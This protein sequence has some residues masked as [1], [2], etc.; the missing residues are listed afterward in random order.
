MKRTSSFFLLAQALVVALLSAAC[1]HTTPAFRDSNG[2]VHANSIAEETYLDTRASRQ[3]L[4]VRGRDRANPAVIFVHGGPGG[5]E[6]ALMRAFNPELEDDLVM[7]YWD[8]RGAGKSY[9]ADTHLNTMTVAQFLQDMDQ[10]VD[11]LRE[12]LGKA[13]IVVMGHFWGSVLGMLYTQRFPDKVA[14]YIGVGQIASYRQ[15]ELHA[16]E[17]V[18]REAR[19]RRDER[20]L[21]QLRKIGPP[22]YTH[23]QVHVRD[24]WLHRYGGYTHAS[25]SLPNVVWKALWTPEA[26]LA[27]LW[28]VW[29]GL[30]RSQ[31]AMQFEFARLDLTNAVLTVE[32]P[33]TFILG[34]YDERT[35]APLAEAYLASLQ[36]PAKRLVW[37]ENSAHNGPFEEPAAFR[38]HVIEAVRAYQA[39]TG[40]LHSLQTNHLPRHPGR[41]STV[42]TCRFGAIPI[43]YRIDR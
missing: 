24:H 17:F 27:D 9:S 3:Y 13:R 25:L 42:P 43:D 35:W 38:R 2:K 19:T 34:R 37:L 6:T 28:R 16:Y 31:K 10:V 1:A 21:A 22:P 14:A 15:A 23:E 18:V 7:A 32:V 5:S 39:T 12:R 4:L 29:R 33:V 41:N 8:Q 30:H 26:G 11:Y 40:R 36:A 20:A